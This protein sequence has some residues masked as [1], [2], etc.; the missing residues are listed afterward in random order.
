MWCGHFLLLANASSGH[1]TLSKIDLKFRMIAQL[2]TVER[3]SFKYDYE[4]QTWRPQRDMCQS[5][6]K[7]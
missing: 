3:K 4:I 1:S 5:K 7:L 2:Q 6:C